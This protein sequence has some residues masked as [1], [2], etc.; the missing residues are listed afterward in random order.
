MSTVT[1]VWSTIAASSMLLAFM[2]GVV[3]A[4]DRKAW[5]S[6]AFSLDALAL[7]GAAVLELHMMS[8]DTP[9]AWGMW[10]RWIQ[11]PIFLR[12]A[13][14]VVFIRLFFGTGRA[15]LMWTIIGMRLFILVTGF[16]VDP[17]FNFSHIES[18][19]RVPFLGDHVTVVGVAAARNIQWIAT[20]ELVLMLVYVVDASIQLWRRG[21]SESRRKALIIGGAAFAT[22]LL[23]SMYSQLM[24]LM[25]LQLPALLSPP[26]LLMLAAM[27]VEMSRDTLR[28][29]RLARDLKASQQRLD[30]VASS[31]GIGLWTWDVRSDRLWMTQRARAMFGLEAGST[32]EV[33]VDQL[34]NTLNADDLARIRK[35]WQHSA[36]AGSEEEVQFRVDLPDGT[37]RW[38]IAHGRTETDAPGEITVVKGVLRDVTDQWRARQENEELRRELAHAGRV[39]ALGTLSSSLIHELSQPLGAIQL[40]ADAAE[41]LLNRPNPDLVEI[42]Q[43]LADIR[44]DDQRA[45]EVIEGLRKF[46]KRRQMDF[47]PVSV[48]NLVADVASL[49]KSDALMRNVSLE[50]VAD[51][52]LPPVRG[53]KVHLSQV[54]INLVMNGMDAVAELPPSSRRVRLHARRNGDGNVEIEVTD[55]GSGISRDALTRIFEPFF[56]TKSGGMGIGLSV[57]QSIVNAHEGKLWAENHAEGGARFRLT[58]PMMKHAA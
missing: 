38:I 32:G 13:C 23:E 21:D 22:N 28:A 55:S 53:D 29:S 11:I 40:N 44:R 19:E 48:D 43:I 39:S 25:G 9:E 15:W 18:I 20:L 36:E 26:Y 12:A 35:A 8:A 56:T 41:L 58:L 51:P 17:N 16:I 50:C 45:G 1:I 52:D 37:A 2:Y 49:L 47:G 46:L 30:E 57:S 4:M 6:L 33:D 24:I 14:V 7:V 5:A 3:W 31:A 34:R 42:R 10:V 54:L 27:T